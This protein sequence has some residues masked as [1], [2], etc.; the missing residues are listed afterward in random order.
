MA[1]IVVIA[2]NDSLGYGLTICMQ[3]LTKYHP[4]SMVVK[5]HTMWSILY[6]FSCSLNTIVCIVWFQT[7]KISIIAMPLLHV[8][9]LK[10][11]IMKSDGHPQ[12]IWVQ[13]FKD[14]FDLR[15]LF[16]QCCT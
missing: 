7:P 15:S 12:T 10:I 4:W 5:F 14:S 1:D 11:H 2:R 16:E 6:I 3:Q 13:H 9:I 8:Y